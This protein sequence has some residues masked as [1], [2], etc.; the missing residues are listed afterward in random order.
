MTWK[1]RA[2]KLKTE[3]PALFLALKDRDTPLTAKIFAGVT[4]AYALSPVDLIPDFIP[5]LG[6]LDDLLLLPAL[7]ALTVKLIPPRRFGT[8]PRAVAGA[9]GKRKAEEMVL[10]PSGH[11]RLA[12]GAARHPQSPLALAPR[13]LIVCG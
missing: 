2:E 13:P 3:L 10:C 5:V 7:V 4:I 8:K 12:G 11:S 1:E 6:Y 9:V